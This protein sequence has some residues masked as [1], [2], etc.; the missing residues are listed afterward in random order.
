[1]VTEKRP[2]DPED[3]DDDPKPPGDNFCLVMELILLRLRL[4]PLPFLCKTLPTDK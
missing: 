2:L 1:M 3:P 4:K